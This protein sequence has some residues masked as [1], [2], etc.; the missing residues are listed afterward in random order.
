LC[1]RLLRSRQVLSKSS[2]RLHLLRTFSSVTPKL[3]VQGISAQY[4]LNDF[5]KQCGGREKIQSLTVKE[6]YDTFIHPKIKA[7]PDLSYCSQLQQKTPDNAIKTVRLPNYF[8]E[9]LW[10][11]P[12]T[13]VLDSLE[14]YF[15]EYPGNN[16]TN[17]PKKHEDSFLYM[18]IFCESS[19]NLTEK[20]DPV[21]TYQRILEASPAGV[22]RPKVLYLLGSNYLLFND[23]PVVVNTMMYNLLGCPLD[24]VV[25][26]PN[27]LAS[28]SS[29]A[30]VTNN[31]TK[32]DL[33]SKLLTLYS[34]PSFLSFYS[35]LPNIMNLENTQP[36][37]ELA[38]HS[39]PKPLLQKV[40]A[41][42]GRLNLLLPQ[43]RKDLE[44][45]QEKRNLVN[46]Q[47]ATDKTAVADFFRYKHSDVRNL[48]E[49]ALSYLLKG[50]QSLFSNRFYSPLNSEERIT[51]EDNP[52]LYL[53]SKLVYNKLLVTRE[54]QEKCVVELFESYEK[55]FGLG[56]PLSMKAFINV[57]L[58]YFNQADFTV[59]DQAIS[60]EMPSA[61]QEELRHILASNRKVHHYFQNVV[62]K[63][64]FAF[65]LNS[66]CVPLVDQTISFTTL[67]KNTI[68]EQ[69]LS[70]FFRAVG[71]YNQHYFYD[72]E[73]NMVQTENVINTLIELN[74]LYFGE[75]SLKA[76]EARANLLNFYL[77]QV[78]ENEENEELQQQVEVWKTSNKNKVLELEKKIQILIDQQETLLK[79]A[80]SPLPNAVLMELQLF[81]A[82]IYGKQNIHEEK[83]RKILTDLISVVDSLSYNTTITEEDY[84][85]CIHVV[86]YLSIY[87]HSYEIAEMLLNKLVLVAK[88]DEQLVYSS[89]YLEKVANIYASYQEGKQNYLTNEERQQSSPGRPVEL[90]AFYLMNEFPVV[91]P[92]YDKLHVVS[93]PKRAIAIAQ[94]L[95]KTILPHFHREDNS[96]L[97]TACHSILYLLGR[98]YYY[99]KKYSEGEPFIAEYTQE[100]MQAMQTNHQ[101][102]MELQ[103]FQKKLADIEEAKAKQASSTAEAAEEEI[104][105]PN[106]PFTTEQL[107]K[108][109]EKTEFDQKVLFEALSE[110]QV[111]LY[112][113]LLQQDKLV[114]AHPFYENF[115]KMKDRFVEK[116]EFAHNQELP[117]YFADAAQVF[118]KP[119]EENYFLEHLH[120]IQAQELLDKD[121]E[122]EILHGVE[123]VQQK[124]KKQPQ[125]EPFDQP[126]V[127]FKKI[128]YLQTFFDLFKLHMELKDYPRAKFIHEKILKL[129]KEIQLTRFNT[130]GTFSQ[131]VEKEKAV[132]NELESELQRE[133][134]KLKDYKII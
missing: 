64:L 84:R 38:K 18:D 11:E 41:F 96:K 34:S 106:I 100:L 122:E 40:I 4:V 7:T 66:S 52:K 121:D 89:M 53:E 86:D 132:F 73:K 33:Q 105:Q 43:E 103:Q 25:H 79:A 74:I 93:N 95:E 104:P 75:L 82:S 46:A 127:V 20:N 80:S 24:I 83:E 128:Q 61:Q 62:E 56:N 133:T 5:V 109:Q 118:R 1:H 19:K 81:L 13:D 32:T 72:I 94:S 87:H 9:N 97:T 29:A 37:S 85:A 114:E 101:M 67:V 129:M 99:Q 102:L 39:L 130:D 22:P 42:Q 30:P 117:R 119:N 120:A 69:E 126:G 110:A 12:F 107:S 2:E 88:T 113:T 57:F 28:L 21:Q 115:L 108:I 92:Y 17:K 49:M 36:L 48:N 8:I 44:S 31:D 77:P 55:K 60:H 134:E 6:V 125:Q 50:F 58:F 15:Q 112:L 116:D 76:I 98:I 68:S 131:F 78:D 54:E 26:N 27:A 123:A 10:F 51:M 71:L 65:F 3:E 45:F 91:Y 59:V 90:S 47:N 23:T 70:A 111:L 14:H 35:D 124:K 16:A 63:R